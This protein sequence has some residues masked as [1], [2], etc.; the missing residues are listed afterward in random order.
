MNKAADSFFAPLGSVYMIVARNQTVTP[1]V[2]RAPWKGKRAK[3]DNGVVEPTTRM[4][5]RHK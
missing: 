4:R 3:L 5:A 2:M 1:N